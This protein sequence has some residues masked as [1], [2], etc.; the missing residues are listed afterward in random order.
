MAKP[1]SIAP[2]V[3]A[4]VG[5][6]AGAA[7]SAAAARRPATPDPRTEISIREPPRGAGA[8]GPGRDINCILLFLVGGPSQLD[9]WDPKPAA[10]DNVRGPFRPIRTNVPGIETADGFVPVR[11]D[12]LWQARRRAL[13]EF[14]SNAGKGEAL[15]SSP[16]I[17]R[18]MAELAGRGPVGARYSG[19]VALACVLRDELFNAGRLVD[20]AA[21]GL[22]DL[23]V[24]RQLAIGQGL[25][26]VECEADG[27]RWAREADGGGCAARACLELMAL[28][29]RLLGS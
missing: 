25:V 20:Q 27:I 19:Y 11:H 22:I 28:R 18:A 29:T 4:S 24:V 17:A 12:V 1:H 21:C 6:T 16:V 13:I 7:T 2:V 5:G 15:A 14:A 8:A 26:D 9:T 23:S 3:A 10:P